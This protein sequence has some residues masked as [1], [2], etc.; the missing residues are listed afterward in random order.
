MSFFDLNP[1]PHQAAPRT[2]GS[3][4]GDA[5]HV[6]GGVVLFVGCLAVAALSVVAFFI[7]L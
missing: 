1:P 7:T 5:L 4:E 2:S 6:L 3:S